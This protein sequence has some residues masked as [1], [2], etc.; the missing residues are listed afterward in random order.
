MRHSLLVGAV[1]D[2]GSREMA[3]VDQNVQHRF[4]VGAAANTGSREV[5]GVGRAAAV[6]AGT[7][8]TAGAAADTAGAHPVDEKRRHNVVR[9]LE[10]Q[11]RVDCSMD[12]W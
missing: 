3:G 12:Y 8:R 7:G 11:K 9:R 4:L 5:A 10:H 6:A 2:R 1:A